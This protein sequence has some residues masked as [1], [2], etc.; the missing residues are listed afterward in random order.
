[1]EAAAAGIKVIVCITEG[2]PVL[3]MQ[4]DWTADYLAPMQEF[5]VKGPSLQVDSWSQ[6]RNLEP[7]AP[8]Q[9]P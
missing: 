6:G 9:K 2:I 7:G 4:S 1:M 3:D 5:L 8:V